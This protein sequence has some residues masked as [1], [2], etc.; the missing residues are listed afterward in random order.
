MEQYTKKQITRDMLRQA[1]ELWKIP[2]DDNQSNFDPLVVMLINACAGELEK[3]H[4]RYKDMS[5]SITESLVE[6]MEP[7]YGRSAMPAHGIVKFSPKLEES[8]LQ[9]NQQLLINL[10]NDISNFKKNQRST[11]PDC[12]FSAIDTYPLQNASVDYL[13]T[14]NS[15]YDLGLPGRNIQRSEI[16]SSLSTSCVYIGITTH[17]NTID[18]ANLPIY[19]KAKGSDSD[20]FYHYLKT[21]T[22]W[23][24]NVQL[25]TETGLT[26]NSLKLKRSLENGYHASKTKTHNI[27]DNVDRFYQKNYIT[28]KDN[29]KIVFDSDKAAEVLQNTNVEA[30]IYPELEVVL[31]NNDLDHEGNIFWIKVEFNSIIPASVLHNLFVSINSYPVVNRRKLKVTYQMK[32]YINI[33]PIIVDKPFLDIQSIE[34]I[35]GK[36]YYPQQIQNAIDGDSGVKG[37]YIIYDHGLGKLE[38]RRA[39]EQVVHLLELLQDESAAFTFMNQEFL[40]S[41]LEKL[42]KLLAT[43]DQKMAESR[44]SDAQTHYLRINPYDLNEHLILTYWVTDGELA[45]GIGVGNELYPY[46]DDY[47]LLN[48]GSFLTTTQ[49]GSDGYDHKERLAR[50]R[51]KTLSGDRI[52][53][54]EDI[55]TFCHVHYGKVISDVVIKQ[56]TTLQ[57][58]R[59]KGRVPC[60]DIILIPSR[61]HPITD[62]NWEYL[63]NDLLHHLRH[64]S[65]NILPYIIKIKQNNE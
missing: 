20:L 30:P 29:K 60:I 59:N 5:V 14:G 43:L 10:K 52:V 62:E 6:L 32:D 39:K 16:E 36:K 47:S 21:A 44:S 34:N 58:A 1:S 61:E 4:G 50:Y 8:L 12:F 57:I 42:D 64:R 33:I 3:L 51:S 27:S 17:N 13:I 48:G 56:S 18:F 37:S 55:K 54:K 25:N 41:N 40:K 46:Q 9:E 15:I 63:N 2:L 49:S 7:D 23:L 24:G 53:T 22:W 28:L 65:L 45:N 26:N 11:L 31:E 19:L 35:K 38:Q